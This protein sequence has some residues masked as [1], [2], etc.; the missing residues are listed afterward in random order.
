MWESNPAVN[1]FQWEPFIPTFNVW[2][3]F[4]PMQYLMSHITVS[5]SPTPTPV[6]SPK[7]GAGRA[8]MQKQTSLN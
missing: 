1:L 3:Q 7:G 6:F 2:G 4:D 8:Q 5:G